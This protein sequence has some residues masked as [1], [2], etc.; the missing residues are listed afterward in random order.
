LVGGRYLLLDVVGRGGMGR[1]WR[2][3]DQLLDREVAVKEVLLPPQSPEEHADLMARTM[4]EAQ[5]AARLGH[6]GVVIVHDVVEHDGAPWIVMQLVSGPS[7]RAEIA[8][9]GRLPWQRVAAIGAQ[10]ADALAHAHG[11]GVVHR[12]LKPDNILL[13]G[14]GAV[15]TDFGIARI[16]DAATELTSSGVRIGTTR[17]MAPEQLEGEAVGPPAD[18]WA[19]GATLYTA[20]EGAPPFGGDTLTA[21]ISAILT[22]EPAPSGNAGPLRD[23]IGMLLYKHP[24]ARPT[25]RAVASALA[26]YGTASAA[27][28]ASLGDSPG[29]PSVTGAGYGTGN[30]TAVSVPPLGIAAP[31]GAGNAPPFAAGTSSAPP[32]WGAGDFEPLNTIFRPLPAGENG[33]RPATDDPA[34]SGQQPGDGETGWRPA[35]TTAPRPAGVAGG[36]PYGRAVSPVT[37]RGV[38]RRRVLGGIAGVAAAG[39]LLAWGLDEVLSGG[40]PAPVTSARSSAPATASLPARAAATRSPAATKSAAP[41]PPGTRLWSVPSPGQM[42]GDVVAAAGV[43]YTADDT[44]NGGPD[45]HNVYAVDAASG[46]VAWR[47]ANYAEQYTGPAAGNGLVYFGSDFH[48]L[49]ALSAKDGHGAWQYT[50]GDVITSPPAVT[51]QAVYVASGDQN[52]YAV[53]AAQG[54]LIWR[55]AL[56]GVTPYLAAGGSYVY[57]ASAAGIAALRP[58][59]GST[60]WLAPGRPLVLAVA[61]AVVI[62]GGDGVLYAADAKTG[63]QQWTCNVGGTVAGIAVAGGVAY[64]GCDDGYV[65][66]VRTA[67]GTLKWARQAGGAVRSGIAVAGGAVYFGCDDH[68]VYAL[69]AA[70]GAVKWTCPTGGAVRSGLAA[71]DGKVFAGSNDGALYAVQA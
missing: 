40:G 55:V 69:D 71:Y 6:P 21:L 31:Y 67:D 46:Q 8:A 54:G 42:A 32:T 59:D 2:G 39:G 34:A 22:R 17:Y 23:L 29:L 47:G 64:T 52:V 66:A 35:R 30:G 28:P 33:G 50:A 60:A 41:R 48:T 61:G 51:G 24:A 49:T 18:M 5:A 62:A 13:T 57:A 44:L 38:S 11:H 1:V 16:I 14:R 36:A 20:A 19:L 15:V 65:R 4:R 58:G 7:L 26:A 43:V 53:R 10:V 12:D 25:A 37:A 3:R 68:K 45:D 63:G 27:R 70:S 56:S 9:A